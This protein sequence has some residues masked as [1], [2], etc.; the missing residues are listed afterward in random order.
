MK[1][2]MAELKAFGNGLLLDY[3]NKVFREVKTGG[4]WFVEPSS[5]SSVFLIVSENVGDDNG[6]CD[7]LETLFISTSNR[8][9]KT[10]FR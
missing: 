1:I 2:P 8:V 10:K 4:R 7:L 6:V 5:S 3:P 9:A